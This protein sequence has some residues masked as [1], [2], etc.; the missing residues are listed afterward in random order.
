LEKCTLTPVSLFRIDPCFAF[1]RSGR[2]VLTIKVFDDADH[3][4]L[5][6]P[7]KRSRDSIFVKGYIE[8]MSGWLEANG[9][10]DNHR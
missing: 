7:E 4:M 5:P 2:G 9:F 8:T 6:S 3:E 10:S 1:K